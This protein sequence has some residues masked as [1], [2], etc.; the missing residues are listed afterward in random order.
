MANLANFK[1]ELLNLFSNTANLTA[2]EKTK[3]RNRFVSEYNGQWLTYLA[4]NGGSDTAAIRG[5]FAVE[6]TVEKW[7]DIYSA[8]SNRENQVALPAAETLGT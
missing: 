4:A 3:L 5:Q 1:T 2:T 7:R 8:G 6:M